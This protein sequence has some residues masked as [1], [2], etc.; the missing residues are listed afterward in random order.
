LHNASR[1]NIG[2]RDLTEVRIT[3]FRV[4]L[5]EAGVIEGIEHLGGTW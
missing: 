3:G 5:T 4:G 1:K 2:R